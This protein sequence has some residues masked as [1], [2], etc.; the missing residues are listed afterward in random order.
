M[1]TINTDS[2]FTAIFKKFL[3]RFTKGRTAGI[4][5]LSK[6]FSKLSGREKGLI[7]LVCGVGLILLSVRVGKEVNKIFLQQSEELKAL[8]AAVVE[9]AEIIKTYQE[10]AERKEAIEQAFKQ[11]GRPEGILSHLERTVQNAISETTTPDISPQAPRPFGGGYEQLPY[12][13]SFRSSELGRI[14]TLLKNLTYGTPRYLMTSLELN[15]RGGQLIDV[16]IEVSSITKS[17]MPP[18]GGTS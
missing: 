3:G 4:L 12:R 18:G 9:T 7:V 16:V 15:P 2:R 11:I 17:E 5:N 6:G 14:V 13:I 1:L 10:A 8:R